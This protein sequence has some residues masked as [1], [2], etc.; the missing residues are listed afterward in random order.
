LGQLVEGAEQAT[1]TSAH[2]GLFGSSIA[3]T[4]LTGILGERVEFFVEEDANRI[5]RTHLGRPI[6]R[7]AEVPSGSVVYTPLAPHI[8]ARIAARLASTITLKLPPPLQ[9]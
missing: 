7:P 2:F 9:P 6:L 8:A 1:R 3:A 4:W 5:G